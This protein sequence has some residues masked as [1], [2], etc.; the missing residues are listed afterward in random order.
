MTLAADAT[1]VSNSEWKFDVS[2]RAE[3][4]AGTALLDWDAADFAGDTIKLNLAD[5]DGA[6]WTLVSG[7]AATQYGEFDVLVDGS[8]ILDAALA[9]D[10]KIVGGVWDGWGFTVEDSALK[11][12]NLA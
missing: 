3:A 6:A 9:L 1:D 11:F 7:A 5:G 8:S 4:L 10:E 2:A 12:K